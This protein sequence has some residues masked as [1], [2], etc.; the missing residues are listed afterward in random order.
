VAELRALTVRQ[1]WAGCIAHL[2]KR[3]ENRS[4]RLP[5]KYLGTEV[6]VH[7][8]AAVDRDNMSA[9][10][11][12]EGWAS[13]FGSNAEWDAWRSWHPGRKQRDMANWP[14]K[15]ALGAV[16]SVATLADCHRFDWDELC[17][18]S[19]DWSESSRHP[20][21]CSPYVVLGVE[22][23]WELAGVRPLA[24]PVPCKGKLGLWRLPE[25]VEKAVRAQLED[26]HAE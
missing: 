13:L 3:I 16:V 11:G 9:P 20:G 6:A 1:P 22:W 14:P 24:E 4:W 17:G 25:D 15:L 8:A 26:G 7:A 18:Y 2:D 5:D 21:L 10:M 12:A 23:H 19:G